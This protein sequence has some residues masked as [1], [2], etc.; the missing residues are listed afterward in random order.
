M[1]KGPGADDVDEEEEETDVPHKGKVTF[2]QKIVLWQTDQTQK[3]NFHF[4]LKIWA[5]KG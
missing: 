2:S 5:F 1:I 4:F 3:L